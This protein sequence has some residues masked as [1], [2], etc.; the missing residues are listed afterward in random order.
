[1]NLSHS[2]FQFFRELA[3]AQVNVN[4]RALNR[5][6]P[7]KRSD[8]MNTPAGASQIGQAKVAHGM[9]SEAFDAGSPGVG[10][11]LALPILR[12]FYPNVEESVRRIY[13]ACFQRTQFFSA[14]RGIVGKR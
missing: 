7:S 4:K 10:D 3:P 5:T 13:V 11:G 14:Q 8:L 9:C 1:M 12:C 6:V 2:T